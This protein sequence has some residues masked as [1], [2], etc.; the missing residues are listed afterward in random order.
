MKLD[1]CSH[2]R[3]L[4]TITARKKAASTFK[5]CLV[6][7]HH[8]F[9]VGRAFR[10]FYLFRKVFGFRLQTND[11]KNS[12]G[13]GRGAEQFLRN[14]REC[15]HCEMRLFIRSFELVPWNLHNSF[16]RRRVEGLQFI[17]C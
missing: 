1:K 15:F 17:K 4:S 5:V 8:I 11:N 7:E 3:G 10:G 12:S 6:A 16:M 9:S 2:A 14:S 13:R